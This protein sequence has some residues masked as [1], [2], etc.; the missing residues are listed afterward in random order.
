MAISFYSGLNLQ[1]LNRLR[2]TKDK[3][4]TLVKGIRAVASQLDPI[5]KLLGKT[6]LAE[7]LV[8][9]KVSCPIGKF[10]IR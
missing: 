1:L 6:E 4:F 10:T 8:L 3:I 7:G 5:G 2:M 9:D